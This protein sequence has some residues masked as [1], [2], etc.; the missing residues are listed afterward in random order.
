V[1]VVRVAVGLDDEVVGRPVEVRFIGPDR[2]VGQGA[3]EACLVDRLEERALEAAAGRADDE[4]SELLRARAVLGVE[5]VLGD[6]L[7][8]ERFAGGALQ[9]GR[10]GDGEV[11]ERAERRRGGEAVARGGGKVGGVVELQA[12]A[13]AGCPLRGRDLDERRQ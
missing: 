9:V 5:L 3:G 1:V 2:V 11:E 10:V 12:A 7:E 8:D 6:E 13:V 4:A